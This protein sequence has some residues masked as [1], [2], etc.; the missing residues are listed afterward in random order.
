MSANADVRWDFRKPG[1]VTEMSV[2]PQKRTSSGDDGRSEKCQ[3]P[4]FDISSSF[5]S[6]NHVAH[7]VVNCPIVLA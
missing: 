4:T 5:A 6:R 2:C 7:A 1:L 3:Q